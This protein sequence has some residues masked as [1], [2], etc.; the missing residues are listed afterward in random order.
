MVGVLSNGLSV[1]RLRLRQVAGAAFDVGFLFERGDERTFLVAFSYQR[2]GLTHVLLSQ[3]KVEQLLFRAEGARLERER[4]FVGLFGRG[5]VAETI[6]GFAIGAEH[7]RIG[8]VRFE[9]RFEHA[10]SINLP[11]ALRK[12]G[13]ETLIDE[14]GVGSRAL[15]LEQVLLCFVVL[16]LV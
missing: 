11:T 12:Q 9:Q 3:G 16:V 10:T 13:G 15:G 8:R 7:V 2:E 5:R 4:A 6:H 1:E 14:L